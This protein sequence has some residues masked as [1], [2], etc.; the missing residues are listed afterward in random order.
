[1]IFDR[2]PCL[3]YS[4]IYADPPW[5]FKTRSDKGIVKSPQ[6]QYDCM[7]IEDIKALPVQF[8]SDEDCVLFMWATWP[9]LQEGLDVI[10]AWG[11]QY[12]TGLAWH[13]RSSTWTPDSPNPKTAFGTGYIFRSAS[14]CLLVGTRGRP[15]LKNRS[16]RNVLEAAVREHSRKPDQCYG[17]IEAMYDGPYLE[18]FARQSAPGWDVWGNQTEKFDFGG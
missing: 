1:M 16:T 6:A 13:K 11:F 7:G 4:V 2:F 9:L 17:M 5:L 3:P 10:K 15:Q 8:C 18:L 12:K 14:E